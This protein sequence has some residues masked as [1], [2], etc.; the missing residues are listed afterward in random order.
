MGTK[1]DFLVFFVG[2]I[3]ERGH[4]EPVSVVRIGI[5][6]NDIGKSVLP[7]VEAICTLLQNKTEIDKIVVS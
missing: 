5:E 4:A 7:N 2:E 3:S 1:G 6:G